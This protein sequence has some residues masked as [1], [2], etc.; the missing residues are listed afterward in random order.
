MD[1]HTLASAIYR[2]A[3]LS[4][5]FLL[6]S[7]IESTEYFDKY[8]FESDPQLLRAVCSALAP[9]IPTDT[10]V[11]AGLEL[12]GV[13]IATMLADITG[14][15]VAFVRKAAKPY[16][17]CQ[18]AE[19]APVDGRTLLIVEDVITSGGQAVI[20]STAL[21]ALGAK[22]THAVCVIDREAGGREALR[23]AG[24]ELRPL[25][26]FSELITEPRSSR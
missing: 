23:E 4:G 19:G 12:G 15:P 18:L 3:H 9:L 11:L 7:G 26:V 22:V 13:P 5:R 21:R 25:F 6:R 1:R 20:S 10:E 17:T 2:T 8:R 16:G 14:L 24:L